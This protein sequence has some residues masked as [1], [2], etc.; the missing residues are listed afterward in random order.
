MTL[1]R[2]L[3]C[4]FFPLKPTKFIQWSI[5]IF[6][7]FGL[8]GFV[9]FIFKITEY[10]FNNENENPSIFA[11]K[12]ILN[13]IMNA[14][15]FYALVELDNKNWVFIYNYGKFILIFKIVSFMFVLS[16][17]VFHAFIMVEILLSFKKEKTNKIV[18]LVNIFLEILGFII[19]T[20][21]WIWSLYLS[22][23]IYKMSTFL[24]NAESDDFSKIDINKLS[25]INIDNN[26]E[27]TI[28]SKTKNESF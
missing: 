7:C 16:R 18:P 12:F 1:A 3:F 21:I 23:G 6:L 9:G 17:F 20:L 15:S 24:K 5:Y 27:D 22:L 2:N 26:S 10:G 14:I 19:G 13:I 28:S 11:L 25:K 8:F 4:F